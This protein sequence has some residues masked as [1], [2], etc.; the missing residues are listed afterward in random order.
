MNDTQ[1]TRRFA[2]ALAVALALHAAVLSG[3]RVPR[4]RLA[5]PPLKTLSVWL[6]TPREISPPAP[7]ESSGGMRPTAR[8][9]APRLVRGPVTASAEAVPAVPRGEPSDKRETAPPGETVLPNPHWRETARTIVREEARRDPA[10]PR[11][12]PA[13]TPE[14]RL[15][16]AWAA[17]RASE[18]RLAGGIVKITTV[19]GTTYCLK[20]PP[21]GP[22][23]G[24]GESYSITVTCP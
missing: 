3:W 8:E 19:F 10:S 7:A 11:E 13:D 9:T 4:A 15:A 24:P 17:P 18:K 21:E 12:T 16:K 5:Q 1:T 6:E 14:A 2:I 23:E 20:P 22:R